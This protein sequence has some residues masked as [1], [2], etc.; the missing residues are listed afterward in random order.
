MRVI[1]PHMRSDATISWE[2][3]ICNHEMHATRAQDER[4]PDLDAVEAEL[5][6]EEVED[7][8]EALAADEDPDESAE[9]RR[10]RAQETTAPWA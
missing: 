2:V 5:E 9:R 8:A 7:E 10:Q 6:L 4:D 3:V 1:I